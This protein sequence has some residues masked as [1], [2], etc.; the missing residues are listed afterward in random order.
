VILEGSIH[1]FGLASVLQ[2][3]AQNAATG[4]LEIRDATEYGFVYLVNGRV[5]GISLP[6]TDELLGTRLL[7][8]GCLAEPQLREALMEDAEL[9]S[10]EKRMKPL[11]QRLVEKGFTSEATIRRVMQ[12]QV[13]DQVFELAHWRN[14]VFRYDEPEEMPAF[15]VAIQGNVQ[16]L[17][18]DAQR[19]IDEGERASKSGGG[20][21]DDVCFE[22]PIQGECSDTI[23][24]K[25]LKHDI[26]LWR[27]MTAV[28]DD[29]S[30]ERDDPTR[31]CE[32][33]T[34]GA[35]PVLDA[36]LGWR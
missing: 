18:L 33:G 6:L 21:L 1:R 24:A 30:E 16:A 5:E 9:T 14:G 3:L 15:Q 8:A 36:S 34:A 27:K 26:C 29:G 25:Y 23:K 10:G 7:K 11:G 13:L 4:V 12:R 22:C 2:F 28:L 31:L 35:K 17:L 32:P 19:R 20:E